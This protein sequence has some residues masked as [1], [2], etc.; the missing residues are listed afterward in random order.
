MK[1]GEGNLLDLAPVALLVPSDLET[2]AKALVAS[3]TLSRI[4]TSDSVP[5]GNP[6]MNAA[7]VIVE[8]RLSDSGF[9]GYSATAWYLFSAPS[10][11][12]VVVAFLDGMEAPTTQIFG[13]D[14]DIDRLAIGFRV[15]HDFGCAL[16]DFR[17]AIR[18]KGSA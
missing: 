7:S 14:S 2:T 3:A 13:F 17:S 5:E 15:F 11:A 16:G 9:S 4:A 12:A 18:M 1:D 10:N 6:F 8:P